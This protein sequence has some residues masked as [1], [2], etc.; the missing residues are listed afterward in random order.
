MIHEGPGLLGGQLPQVRHIPDLDGPVQARRSE[1]PTGGSKATPKTLLGVPTERV[2]QSPV[3]ASQS[4]TVPSQL[5]EASYRPSGLYATS[6][7]RSAWPDREGHHQA[8]LRVQERHSVRLRPRRWR[9][10]GCR[11]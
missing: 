4:F 3:F 5:A 6:R 8:R 9:S 11:G 7:I 2:E 10:I 1:T